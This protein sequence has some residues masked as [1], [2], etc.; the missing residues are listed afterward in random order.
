MDAVLLFQA[1]LYIVAVVLA[2]VAT[3]NTA[4]PAKA[5]PLAVGFVAAGLLV[6]ILDGLIV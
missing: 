3:W 2:V 6:P 4:G 5:F 1:L